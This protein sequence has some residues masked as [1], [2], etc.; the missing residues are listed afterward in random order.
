MTDTRVF[1]SARRSLDGLTEAEAARLIAERGEVE[2]TPT[3]RSLASIVRANVLTVFNLILVSF[4]VLTFAFGHWEDALFLAILV[5][6]SGIGI[7]QEWRAKQ[8]LDRLAALVAPHATVVRDG[9]PRQVGVEEV[10]DGD[11]IRVESGDQLVADGR[12]EQR[13]RSLAR[14]V[15]PHRRVTRPWRGSP[16]TRCA[17][18]RSPRRGRDSTP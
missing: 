8:A 6:N 16:A 9:R 15:D 17:P 13:G 14:R 1:P 11:L 7:Y 5:A 10:V 4:G 2:P 12:L 3:S 18:G